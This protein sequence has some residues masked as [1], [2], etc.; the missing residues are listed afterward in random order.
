VL[1]RYEGAGDGVGEVDLGVMGG[2]EEGGGGQRSGGAG[3]RRLATQLRLNELS[4]L[5]KTCQWLLAA[6]E[7]EDEE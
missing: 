6:E 4:L 7:E 1:Q 3:R 5:E 2:E